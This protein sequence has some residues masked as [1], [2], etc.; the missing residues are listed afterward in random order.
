MFFKHRGWERDVRFR[1]EWLPSS[2]EFG[3]EVMNLQLFLKE[4]GCLGYCCLFC[5]FPEICHGV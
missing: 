3:F 4:L 1:I 5:N 2:Q